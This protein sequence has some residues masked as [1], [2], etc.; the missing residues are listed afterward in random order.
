MLETGFSD[1][2]GRQ[3]IFCADDFAITE[4]VSDAI[5]ELADHG[6]LSATSAIVTGGN[7]HRCG[8][9]LARLRGRIA[10]GLHL[11]LTLGSPLGSM[12][13]LAP[14]GRF[15]AIGELLGQA[16][17]RN[18][19]PDEIAAETERQIARFNEVTGA[20]PDFVDGHQHA[21]ALP[22]VRRGVLAALN[23]CFPA[24]N[25]LVRDPA[26]K[27]RAII[28][29]NVATKKA[30]GIAVLAH[31]FREACERSGAMTNIGFSGVSNFKPPAPYADEL[32]RFF[33]SP[34]PRHLVMC[35]PGFSDAELAR[36]DPVTG[37][38]DEEFRAIREASWLGERIWRPERGAGTIW[39]LV[40]E[41]TKARA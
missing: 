9:R 14:K 21:H 37:R 39:S 7:W 18:I 15:P 10:V 35:H 24:G 6:Q 32:P 17:C 27:L 5:E 19:S 28:R 1:Q 29:R 26:D 40:P 3:V 41:R 30:I 2:A 12:G 8:G 16:L 22:G 13:R 11:N 23:K 20:P 34:G 31:G 33:V 38:R 25:V 36:L 4:G